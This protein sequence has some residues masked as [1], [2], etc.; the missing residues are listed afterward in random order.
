MNDIQAH[1][2]TYFRRQLSDAE[3][4]QFEERCVQDA[5]FARQVALYISTEEGI[6]QQL[7]QEKKQQWRAIRTNKAD[8]TIAPV[9]KLVIR[10]WIVYAAAACVLLAVALMINFRSASPHQMAD[11]YIAQHYTYLSQTMNA[12]ADSLQQ[13]IAAYNN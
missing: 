10:K 8:T 3:M 7:L 13:G 5:A 6:R 1:V 12:S 11:E 2:E 4:K 9:R